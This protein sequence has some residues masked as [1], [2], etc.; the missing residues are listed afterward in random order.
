MVTQLSHAA[1]PDIF[2]PSEDSEPLA[3]TYDHLYA[4][5]TTLEVLKQF[6][7]G[8]QATV[9]SDQSLARRNLRT[10]YRW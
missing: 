6:L 10:D 9:L 4:I 2:Y 1:P 3:E 5:L 7:T 8:L